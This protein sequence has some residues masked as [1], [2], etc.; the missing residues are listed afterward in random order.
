L[1]VTGRL[2]AESGAVLPAGAAVEL[3]RT[4]VNAVSNEATLARMR[5]VQRWS[6]SPDAGAAF[7]SPAWRLAGTC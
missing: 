6:T 4:W 2:E 3:Q 5:E 1:S 7:A